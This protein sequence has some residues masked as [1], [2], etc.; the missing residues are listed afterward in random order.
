MTVQPA[1]SVEELR[2]VS[3]AW[4]RPS[5]FI[6]ILCL[7]WVLLV[8]I[9]W[10]AG[11]N[12]AEPPP[13]EVQVIPQAEPAQLL[14]PFDSAP[15]VEVKPATA[16]PVV[17]QALEAQ[18][19]HGQEVAELKPLE[20]ALATRPSPGV[21]VSPESEAAPSAAPPPTAPLPAAES[22]VTSAGAPE[23]ASA[24]AP[25]VPAEPPSEQHVAE[26]SPLVTRPVAESAQPAREAPPVVASASAA[27]PASKPL[28]EQPVAESEPLV[29]RPAREPP[30][31][32]MSASTIGPPS[33]P[34]SS[35]HQVAELEPLE[36]RPSTAH[37]EVAQPAR[38]PL[39]SEPSVMAIDPP[40]RPLSSA[41]QPA[42]L[43][44]L[45]VPQTAAPVSVGPP[46]HAVPLAES[47][48][49]ANNS[50]T[51]EAALPSEK[52][53]AK[54]EPYSPVAAPLQEE[55]PILSGRIG[56]I[57]RYVEQYDGG[58]CFFVA[59]V[60]VTETEA[61]LEGYGASARP[62]EALDTAF[63]HEHG[64]EASI[65][66]RLVNPAQCP[67]V[68]FLGRLRGSNA[69][70]LRIDGVSLTP[71]EVLTGTVDG[72]GGRNVELLVATDAGTVQNLSHLLKLDTNAKTFAIGRPDI[73]WASAGQPQLLIV[74]AS[75][76]PLKALRFDRP[77]AA[78]R[79]FAAAL[80][81]AERT[82]QPVAAMARY[83]KLER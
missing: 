6:L 46:T 27:D 78:D 4:L 17:A 68:S 75:P 40:S 77:V 79:V 54:L 65:D 19:L 29:A 39:R 28:S 67:A 55:G 73:A 14:V 62:F 80:G 83:F 25:V 41:Q 32:E 56:K 58:R 74:V 44:P 38:Q 66:V 24:A 42:G 57:V 35:K 11:T 22:A 12:G 76:L 15:V 33:R 49:V 60:A 81:E 36:A 45:E 61:R 72:F 71:G 31:A 52:Q 37:A 63:R 64:F 2:R 18:P 43:A 82:N 16:V 7:H 21:P 26:L 5:A 48:T 3:P 59:P 13:F 69:P 30:I 34:L 9:R 70:H 20:P 53:V 23:A 51:Q 50:P 10:P 8:E 47:S 1:V